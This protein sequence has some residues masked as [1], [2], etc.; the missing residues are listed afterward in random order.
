MLLPDAVVQPVS[1]LI[2]MPGVDF[3]GPVP[4][5]IQYVSVFSTAIV[6]GSK[7]LESVRRLIAFLTSETAKTA[8]RNHGMEPAPSR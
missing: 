8:I 4:A 7:E 3:V 6:A 1:E 2:H 5:E